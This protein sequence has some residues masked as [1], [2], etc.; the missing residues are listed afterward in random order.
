MAD[1]ALSEVDD[2]IDDERSSSPEAEELLA[3]ESGPAASLREMEE[4]VTRFLTAERARVRKVRRQYLVPT[5][6]AER[7]EILLGQAKGLGGPAGTADLEWER[8]VQGAYNKA[9]AQ[10]KQVRDMLELLLKHTKDHLRTPLA[11][12]WSRRAA[13]LLQRPGVTVS[14][15]AEQLTTFFELCEQQ[16][17]KDAEDQQR[18][19]KERAKQRAARKVE[20]EKLDDDKEDEDEP[21]ARRRSSTNATAAAAR[22]GG[23][24]S[25]EPRRVRKD[26]MGRTIRSPLPRRA[27]AA[28]EKAD[29]Q[30]HQRPAPRRDG[31]DGGA[32]HGDRVLPRRRGAPADG[33]VSDS[34]SWSYSDYASDYSESRAGSMS[35]ERMRP[36]RGGG[37]RRPS[38]SYSQRRPRGNGRCAR[39]SRSRSGGGDRRGGG[40]RGGDPQSDIRR[41]VSV[42]RLGVAIERQLKELP[43]GILHRVMYLPTFEL[44]GDVRDP[45]AIVSARIRK[46]REHEALR[47]SGQ[48]PPRGGNRDQQP[49]QQRPLRQRG[50]RSLSRDGGGRSP[51]R[52]T[53]GGGGGGGAAPSRSRSPLPRTGSPKRLQPR[54]Q[55][56]LARRRGS[57]ADRG[58]AGREPPDRGERDRS[59]SNGARGPDRKAPAAPKKPSDEDGDSGDDDGEEA[60]SGEKSK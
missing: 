31:K 8:R 38:R 33:S 28:A 2:E 25:A 41:F 6:Q 19:E 40:G 12:A 52:R 23:D 1:D 54:R 58:A 57:V 44:S 26:R 46:A 48:L 60:K 24:A 37:H 59:S 13:A 22:G 7:V 45:T 49:R 43:S 51:L 21:L 15:A 17:T 42:N 4:G 11:K 5:R 56:P 36:Q 14:E 50:D 47:Q 32:R 53:G 55:S 10:R 29:D 39:D 35:A 20:D 34:R 3:I 27:G 9:V 16:A 18:R 30:Q